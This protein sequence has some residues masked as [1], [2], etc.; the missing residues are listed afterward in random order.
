[1][2]IYYLVHTWPDKAFKGTAILEW[3]VTLTN[4]PENK[5]KEPWIA[6]FT[7]W[8]RAH[9]SFSQP[10]GTQ[11]RGGVDVSPGPPGTRQIRLYSVKHSPLANRFSCLYT[12]PGARLSVP[13]LSAHLQVW[14]NQSINQ[15]ISQSINQIV[16]F[17]T[18]NK[19]VVLFANFDLILNNSYMYCRL[20]ALPIHL[21][22]R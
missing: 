2:D 12:A 3:R 21:L 1:M 15:T 10:H 8:W 11:C 20:Y 17:A 13:C 19:M 5:M 4:T 18:C 16:W 9:S 22:K 7:T 14:I 6:K